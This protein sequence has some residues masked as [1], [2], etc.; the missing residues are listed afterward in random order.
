VRRIVRTPKNWDR[1]VALALEHGTHLPPVADGRALGEFLVEA[2]DRD[3]VHFPDLSLSVVKLIGAGE[4]VIEMPGETTPGHFGL[5]V[6]DYA[7]STAPNRRFPDLIT[8]RLVKAALAGAAVPYTQ[9]ELQALAQHCTEQEDEAKKAERQVGKSAAALLLGPRIGEVFTGIVTGVGEKGTWLRILQP[10]VEGKLAG[11]V[12]R[13]Q[14]GMRI[15]AKLVH[16]DVE[17]GYIDFVA[18]R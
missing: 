10:P 18:A 6:K 14:V 3:A 12:T 16:V 17:R 1:I 5:A 13:L 8:Q 4:Y 11:D 9:D 15:Q 2:R 7:H